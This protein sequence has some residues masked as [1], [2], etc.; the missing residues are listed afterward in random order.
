MDVDDNV[1]CIIVTGRGRAFCA[2]ADLAANEA[3]FARSQA[4][5]EMPRDADAGGILSRRIFDSAKPV[6]AAIN[7][8][9]I[10]IGLTMTLGM[11]VRLASE[12]A[13][14]GF[15]FT[16]RGLV[17]EAASSF[18]LPRLVG[19][20]TACEWAFSGRIFEAAEAKE[21]GLVRSVHPATSLLD[22]ARELAHSM[23]DNSSPVAVAVTRRMF[24]QMYG[25]SDPAAAHE[26]D[27][28]AF[29]FLGNSQDV[30]EG[31]AA[32][33]EKRPPA[34]SMRVSSDLPEFFYRW[35]AERG[36]LDPSTSEKNWL[37][38]LRPTTPG[39]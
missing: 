8:P 21:A 24:W 28:E 35:G 27:S 37:R 13:R 9:A 32:F 1:R 26:M 5:F 25:N 36:G 2:G 3:P 38:R 16:R 17:P 11:D 18:F 23:I 29:H 19:I 34:F 33:L 4:G 6:I 10:G 31:V 30:H 22:A 12:T 15:V 20:S 39:T 14:F 7:G